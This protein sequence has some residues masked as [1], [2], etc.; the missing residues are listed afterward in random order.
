MISVLKENK[1]LRCFFV[2]SL[3]LLTVLSN[4]SPYV[5]TA[6]AEVAEAQSDELLLDR[7]SV[8]KYLDDGTDQGR[9]WKENDFNDS[10]W[11]NGAAPLGYPASEK[12]GT[13][14]N[15]ATI[16]D[17]GG[18][19][20]NKHATSYF[21]TTFEVEDLSK[22]ST[23]GVITA[24]IDD[25]AII[26][27]NGKEIA[28]FN[29]PEGEEIK[30][31]DYVQDFGLNDAS[32]INDK[33]FNLTDEQMSYIVKG[34][35]V[36]AVEVHQ[37][38]PSSSDVFFDMEFKS[39]Y[40]DP[41]V[42]DASYIFF[43]PGADE[44]KYN[45]SWYSP[46]TD[47]PGV[48]E[49]AKVT[50]GKPETAKTVTATL[51]P[52]S[53]GYQANE[54]TIT[55]IEGSSEYVYRL[56]DGNG[57]WSE[58]Y[59]FKTQKTDS[60]NFLFTGDP[61]IGSSGNIGKDTEG[62]VSTLNKAI[63]RFPNT[64]FI[65]SAGDQVN[66]ANS[67]EEYA[68][69]FAPGKL[70]Q[71]PTATTIG[72]HDNSRV[73]EYHFNTPYQNPA[74][75]NS[76]NAGGDYYFT[77]GDTLI[78]NLNSNNKNAAEHTQFMEETIE[79]T[80][81]RDFKWKFVVFHH[82]IYSAASHSL[83]AG[84]IKLRED[85]V[86]T[87]DKLNIDVVLMGHD[88]SYVRTYQM[89]N[90]Q[91]LKNQMIAEDG[92]VI[93]PEGTLYLTANSSSGSK[94]YNLKDPEFYSADRSQL[95]VPTFTN[96]EVTPT[97]L[98]FTTY[99]VDTMEVTDSY[100]IVKD[101]SIE[102]VLP[103]LESV[104]LEASSNVVPTEPST[105]YPEVSLNVTGK[106]VDGGVYDIAFEDITYKTSPE[107]ELSISQ[108][109]KVTVG[110]GAKPVK[111]QVWAEVTN[112]GK[113]FE[114]EKVTIQIVEHAEQTIFEKWSNWK[115]LDDGS[116]Q[117]TAWRAPDFD[118]SSWMSGVAPLGYSAS[119]NR[120]MFGRVNTVINYG[121]D[122]SNKIPTYYFRTSFEVEDLSKIGDVGHINFGIDDSVILYLN[123]HE[124]GRHNLPEGEIGYDKYLSD[125]SG[126]NVA[127]ESRYE[128][129][130]LDAA[131]LA[132]LV[133]GTNVLA[134]EVH[135]DRPTS[136]DI[137]WDMEFITSVNKET[138]EEPIVPEKIY[139]YKNYKTGKLMIHDPSV[140]ITLD[141]KSEIK[142]GV[143]FTGEYAEFHGEG[144][145]Y[146]IVTIKPK[147]K[148]N[149]TIVDFKGTKISK[150][151][152]EGDKV[153]EIRGFENVAEFEYVKGANPENIKFID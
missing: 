12:H 121:P 138:K 14:G 2:F 109:G 130:T 13:F 73:Y 74:L 25:S 125:L 58:S 49:Y 106:N 34:T 22:I 104:S 27:L 80:K 78:M 42:Y 107:G 153:T 83:E 6:V 68:G 39:I 144:F 77:Y 50:D 142:N 99:R 89:K 143:V 137:Y 146:T 85:L 17:Y 53:S 132:H 16:I 35:N 21:R 102:V 18:D 52:A 152:I 131:D 98:A 28:R 7:G 31:D 33:I 133:K 57:K 87:F 136:S 88:H 81:D 26:Y 120:P 19:S 60:Y 54:V 150:V 11:K 93:N 72:N 110:E 1:S 32:E 38:R 135:Q 124:I 9:A 139:D 51:E 115:Y 44:T 127:D 30:F 116:D 113:A 117:G 141:E 5:G 147:N 36:L 114:T 46:Q 47:V 45:F 129:F 134:A 40:V 111:V 10:E 96:I 105:F 59:S 145:A 103:A 101:P 92:S 76:N 15:I 94:Y 67:E 8:W 123:G 75:G 55:D 140:S 4:L 48:I 29:L 91:P 56:G 43:A 41:T 95:R 90:L 82:S 148:Y 20:Q 119:E 3:V 126:S 79:A 69:F 100:K 112:E 122:A 61:Q 71:Y 118:D 37:D 62:W 128:T 84:I 97:S 151:I 70:K 86:P 65:Q 66:D 63:E 108:D 149:G 24:G 23:S 64:S